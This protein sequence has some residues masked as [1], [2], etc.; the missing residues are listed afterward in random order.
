MAKVLDSLR[1]FYTHYW[2]FDT[3]R[4]QLAFYLAQ[5]EVCQYLETIMKQGRRLVKR[6]KALTK[7]EQNFITTARWGKVGRKYLEKEDFYFRITQN[8]AAIPNAKN[9]LGE[10]YNA[11]VDW[12][13]QESDDA[14]RELDWNHL[15]TDKVFFSNVAEPFHKSDARQKVIATRLTDNVATLLGCILQLGNDFKPQKVQ[16]ANLRREYLSDFGIVMLCTLFLPKNDSTAML[17]EVQLFEHRPKAKDDNPEEREAQNAMMRDI[18]QVYR[19]RLPNG[20]RLDSTA[21]DTT[22]GMDMLNELRRCPIELYSHLGR[23]DRHQFEY[24]DPQNGVQCTRT[25]TE[26][27]F[28]QLALHYIDRTSLLGDIRFQVRLGSYR[29]RFN[30]VNLPDGTS[31]IVR[32]AKVITAFGPIDEVEQLRHENYKDMRQKHTFKTV[33]YDDTEVDILQLSPDQPSADA[34]LTDNHATYNIHTNRIGLYW[35]TEAETMLT[36]SK[37]CY[38]PQ[39]SND[40]ARPDADQHDRRKAPDIVMPAP[41]CSLSLNELSSLLF[42]E[43]LRKGNDQHPSAADIIKKC[44]SA[45]HRLL[46]D[47]ASGKLATPLTDTI[48]QERYA[49]LQ[50]GDVPK[51]LLDALNKPTPNLTQDYINYLLGNET[52]KSGKDKNGNPIQLP[53]FDGALQQM[54]D[55]INA[56]VLSFNNALE[57]ENRDIDLRPGT[58]A[59]LL[60]KDI[61]NWMPL[62][63]DRADRGRLRAHQYRSLQ[64][65]LSNYGNNT[66]PKDL[67]DILTKLRIIGHRTK[68][69]KV[70]FTR[71]HPFLEKVL[72]KT[73]PANIHS[74]Y[75]EYFNF[76]ASYLQVI[77]LDYMPRKKEQRIKYI[78]SHIPFVKRELERARIVNHEATLQA[79]RYLEV[80]DTT[81]DGKKVKHRACL[82]LPDKLFLP[83]IKE[84]LS[85]EIVENMPVESVNHLITQYYSKQ[86]GEQGYCQPFY[87][88]KRHYPL[89]DEDQYLLPD[90]V[91]KFLR[92]YNPNKVVVEQQKNRKKQQEQNKKDTTQDIVALQRKNYQQASETERTLRQLRTQDLLLFPMAMEL[93]HRSKALPDDFKLNLCDIT[94]EQFLNQTFDAHFFVRFKVSDEKSN[95]QYEVTIHQDNMTLSN[96]GRFYSLLTD[97]RFRDLLRHVS[98]LQGKE[99]S[100][101]RLMQELSTYDQSRSRVFR[102]L[103]RIEQAVIE[104]NP[105]LKDPTAEGFYFYPK[106]NV[107]MP[108]RNSFSAMIGLIN[109]MAD[110]SKEAVITVR[111]AFSHNHFNI[112]YEASPFTPDAES[113]QRYVNWIVEAEEAATTGDDPLMM[114]QRVVKF[115][116]H[117]APQTHTDG[118]HA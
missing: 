82:M 9:T 33:D 97:N 39:L 78:A 88:M 81:A 12:V 101:N 42:Y 51:R 93:L 13:K 66:S 107:R 89:F 76:E 17:A 26:D 49:P 31:S 54:V 18:L 29:F 104:G 58:L 48:M 84:L 117:Q 62:N 113:L 109:A 90:E 6:G 63:T 2:H 41:L 1:N 105:I 106:E 56:R 25:R 74:L 40:N 36:G 83:H 68:D 114:T 96:Y 100:Y 37:L 71:N 87:E 77:V 53:Q 16:Y 38:L 86:A 110:S 55:E 99:I 85:P 50:L 92:E 103:H 95:E 118:N 4:E 108:I 32:G 20:Q 67:R 79:Q 102:L 60:A 47:V 116:E 111:N 23:D 70:D 115:T 11:A 21:T 64:A 65:W 80:E 91:R 24:I 34:Y 10:Q 44:Y 22:L 28:S 43:Q 52:V 69:G 45:M 15:F 3:P 30:Q 35:N 46:T 73:H 5:I 59:A 8:L 19:M 61:V 7:E 98:D 112:G 27:R 72:D 94:G 14:K 75:K 57:G